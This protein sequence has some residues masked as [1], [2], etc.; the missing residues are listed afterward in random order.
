VQ[1]TGRERRRRAIVSVDAPGLLAVTID[2]LWIALVIAVGV[3]VVAAIWVVARFVS[4]RAEH[5]YLP[6][7]ALWSRRR[8][9]VGPAAG[10]WA[11]PVCRSVNAPTVV[12]CY[13][14]GVPRPGEAVELAEIHEDPGTY[15][16]PAPANRFDPAQYRGPG[17]P[18]EA[19]GAVE[20]ASDESDAAGPSS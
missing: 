12:H 8:A 20:S 4:T 1:S 15:H 2:L 16:P 13:G 5:R 11:C 7:V 17:A 10:P 6:R 19:P 14:C 3:W 18:P 9:G